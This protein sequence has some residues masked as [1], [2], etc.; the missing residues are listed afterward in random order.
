MKTIEVCG[1]K[2]NLYWYNLSLILVPII[3]TL[4]FVFRDSN[5]IF[6][7]PLSCGICAMIIFVNFPSIVIVLHSRPIYFDDLIIKNYEGQGYI[8]DDMFRKK[9]QNIFRWIASITSSLMIALTAEL[10]FFR[11]TMFQGESSSSGSQA[12]SSFVVLGIIGGM[13]RLYYGATMILGNLLLFILRRLKRKEQER[14][15]QEAQQRTL[16][17]LSSVGVSISNDTEEKET[18][19]IPR[20]VSHDN[21]RNI[22]G[23]KPTI[24]MTDLFN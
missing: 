22:V 18:L 2:F 6:Y 14:M 23:F 7:V 15:R 9:Y 13:L 12:V 1:S 19:I 3:L 17:E 21:L 8:Y 10:W 16:V 11:D 5:G 24:M 4:T 20:A